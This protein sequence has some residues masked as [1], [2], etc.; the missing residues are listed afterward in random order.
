[1]TK[2][3]FY[4][5]GVYII[6]NLVNKKVYIGSTKNTFHSRRRGHF[7]RLI[8]NTHNNVH[9][10]NSF[11]KYGEDNFTFEILAIC[12]QQ[13]CIPLENICINFYKSNKKEYGYN[14]AIPLELP[15]GNVSN[16]GKKFSVEHKNKISEALKIG[17]F[18]IGKKQPK[19]MIEKRSA[20]NKKF[21]QQIS[22]ET[23]KVL[24]T[25]T[26]SQAIELG[27]SPK[28]A[29]QYI[30]KNRKSYRGFDWKI[31]KQKDYEQKTN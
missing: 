2:E 24:N 23:G 18:W 29:K 4:R 17:G 30:D 16:K 26:Y 5:C 20:K 10:Q 11:N 27:F 6:T 31:L 3:D 13:N 8:K 14:I 1:M 25:W 7:S 28:A 21:L 15:L 19:E 12:D 9:L 22:K